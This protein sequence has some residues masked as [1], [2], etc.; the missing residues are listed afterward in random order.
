L[1][2][3]RWS[4]SLV[5]IVPLPWIGGH[6]GSLVFILIAFASLMISVLSPQSVGGLR[7]GAADMAAPVLETL[8]RPVQEAAVFV[9]NVSGI[10]QL[11]AENIRLEQ[12]N[13]RLREWYQ[14]A[15]VL[16]AEN[17]SLRDLLNV[18]IDPQNSYITAR[19]LADSGN[20]FVKSLLVSAGSADG[21][22]KGQAVLSGDGVVGRVIEVGQDTARVLLLTDMNSRVPVLVENSRQHAILAGENERAPV[23]MH[24][25]PDSVVDENARIITSGQGGIFPHGLPVGRVVLD[26]NRVPQVELFADFDRMIHVRIVD[27]PEDPNLHRAAPEE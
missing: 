8:S 13:L 2:R 7:S 5:R 20:T 26:K 24:L 10:T 15:L 25:P 1:K 27:R 19:V 23:L 9:R 12:E 14:T 18:R 21:V 17:K 3:R 11:Q 4:K 6:V 16:E 22:K